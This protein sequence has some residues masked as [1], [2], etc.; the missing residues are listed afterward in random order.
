MWAFETKKSSEAWNEFIEVVHRKNGTA[1]LLCKHCDSAF[2]HPNRDVSKSTSTIG[3]HLRTCTTYRR[4]LHLEA[5]EHSPNFD[6]LDSLFNSSAARDGPVA[7]RDLI[8]ERVLRI[9]IAGNLPFSFA[10]NDEFVDLLKDAYP[11]CPPPNRRAIVEYLKAKATLTRHKL[12]T[13]LGELD[14][15]VSIALDIWTTRTNLAF[16]GMSSLICWRFWFS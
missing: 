14:S 10:E 16:F 13:M 6:I 3:K 12:K 9:I 7:T 2:T 5:G 11:D 4:K 15:K 8:K 1:H